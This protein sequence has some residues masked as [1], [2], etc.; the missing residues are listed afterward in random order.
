MLTSSETARNRQIASTLCH[1]RNATP[2]LQVA[3]LFRQG[4][5]FME[6]IIF[7]GDRWLYEANPNVELQIETK[8]F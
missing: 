4:S 6:R 8:R 3:R 1:Y 5:V 2:Q 7:P